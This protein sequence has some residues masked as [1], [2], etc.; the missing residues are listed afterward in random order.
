MIK[1]HEGKTLNSVDSM[2]PVVRG[3]SGWCKYHSF[4]NNGSQAQMLMALNAS[5]CIFVLLL[6]TFGGF[7]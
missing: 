3:H 2:I 1:D 4:I 7:A 6:D 5:K